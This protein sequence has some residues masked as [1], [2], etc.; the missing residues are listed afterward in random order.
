[1]RAAILGML[2]LVGATGIYGSTREHND[3]ARGIQLSHWAKR[4]VVTSPSLATIINREADNNSIPRSLLFGL[5]ATESGFDEHAIRYEP[6]LCAKRSWLRDSSK[7]ASVGLTQVI[8]GFHK[9]TCQ[10]FNWTE[11]LD[12]ETNVMCGARILGVLLRKE[13]GG[14]FA[15]DKKIGRILDAYNGDKTGQYR[16]KVLAAAKLYEGRV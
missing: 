9:D 14:R 11:L 2:I 5:I 16:R 10:L 1:M 3:S 6:Y 15:M 8:Y 13:S 4:K 7:C 12:P